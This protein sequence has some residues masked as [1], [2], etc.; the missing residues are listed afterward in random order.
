MAM[1]FVARPDG[2]FD[3]RDHR[4]VIDAIVPLIFFHF[5]GVKKGWGWF[6]FN[7][8]RV[9]RAPFSKIVRDHIYRPYV[10]ELLAIEKAIKPVLPLPDAR[11]HRRSATVDIRQYLTSKVRNVGIRVLQLLDIATG[12]AF[13]V[14]RG[15]AY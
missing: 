13:L 12:R 5:Q 14:F 4:V 11:P 8:H 1:A 3:F 15:T 10:R 6:I 2:V 9:H 7:S